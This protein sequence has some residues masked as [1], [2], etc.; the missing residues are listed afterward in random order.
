MNL[1]LLIHFLITIVDQL[2]SIGNG[3]AAKERS[4]SKHARLAQ[5]RRDASRKKHTLPY[6][7]IT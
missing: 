6:H 1:F 7:N 5:A 3:D 4:S 2:C